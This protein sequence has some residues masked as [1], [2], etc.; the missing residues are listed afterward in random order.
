MSTANEFSAEEIVR[1]LREMPMD[2]HPDVAIEAAGLIETLVAERD[3]LKAA[4]E[5]I[6]TLDHTRPLIDARSIARAALKGQP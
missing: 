6:A 1:I 2:V 3:Q 5:A 4:L